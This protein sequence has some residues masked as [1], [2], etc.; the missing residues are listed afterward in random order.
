MNSIKKTSRIAGLLY[1]GV[2]VFGIIGQLARSSLIVAGDAATTANNIMAN[3]MQFRAANV[4]W[5]ISEMFLLLLGLAL[6]VVLKKVNQNLASLMLLFVV[7]GVAIESINTLNQ[8]AALQLL[9]GADYLTVFSVDQ[10]NAQVMSHL[11]SWEA[12]YRIAAIL[13]F[14]PWLIPAGYLVY[15][16]GYFP[17]ILGVLV[18]LAGFGLLIEGLQYFLLPDYE[19]ISYPGSVVASIGEFAFCGWLLLKVLKYPK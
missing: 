11:D 4:S 2:I 1:L 14:G 3:E 6:Y 18:I 7:V 8:F 13:S 12:G 15:K 10:L 17:R 16:S 19:V 9:S 5:L